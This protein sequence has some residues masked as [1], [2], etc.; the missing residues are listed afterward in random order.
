MFKKTAA[1]QCVDL[2]NALHD[3]GHKIAPNTMK[4][5]ALV[6]SEQVKEYCDSAL[7]YD[8]SNALASYLDVMSHL[9]GNV[10]NALLEYE[11]INEIVAQK[12]LPFDVTRSAHTASGFRIVEKDHG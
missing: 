2:L 11:A 5:L 4:T 6:L 8:D 3:A 7:P 9:P 1:D 10:E 12:E